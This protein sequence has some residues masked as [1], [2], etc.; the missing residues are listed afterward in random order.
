MIY[1]KDFSGVSHAEQIQNAIKEASQSKTSKTV[2]L[3]EKD[4]WIDSPI[5]VLKDVELLFGYGSK[6]VVGA[7]I[8]VLGLETNASITNPYIA[9]DN[10][11]FDSPV[12]LLDGKHKYYNTWNRTRISHGVVVNW[13]GSNKGTGIKLYSGDKDHEISF[14]N[15]FD[16]KFT[17]LRKGIELLAELP[18]GSA[19]WSWVN[20]NRF[21]DISIDDCV[22]MITI[23]GSETTPNECSGNIFS[24][25]QLQVTGATESILK[26][27][28][29]HNRFDG[30]IWDIHSMKPEYVAEISRQSAYTKLD[31]NRS[32]PTSRVMNLGRESIII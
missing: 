2:Q 13:T 28:G 8:P 15:V 7:D 10:P 14:V 29:Q 21:Q 20:A 25:L 1:A 12:F 3:E 27:T 16:V 26:V 17:G 24:G 9:I 6:L 31:F 22:E 5:N 11:D 4:Y 19:G 18:E 23:N 30:M 32:L